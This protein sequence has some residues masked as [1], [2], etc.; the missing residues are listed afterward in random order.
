MHALLFYKGRRVGSR[1]ETLYIVNSRV[2][3][4][5]NICFN[6]AKDVHE[7]LPHFIRR[8]AF[9]FINE[10]RKHFSSLVFFILGCNVSTCLWYF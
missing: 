9:R 1:K 4:N 6:I 3:E 7:N 10:I 8:K 2:L 5:G